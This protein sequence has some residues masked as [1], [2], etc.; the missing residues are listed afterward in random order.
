LVYGSLS[1]NDSWSAT[2]G[3]V[4]GGL[5]PGIG[6]A[7]DIRDFGAAVA[8]VAN[9]DEGAWVELGASI[10]GFVPG[11]DIAKGTTKGA[12]K[13]AAEAAQEVAN[14]ARASTAKV[15]DVLPNG[16][17]PTRARS[18]SPTARLSFAHRRGAPSRTRLHGDTTA[19]HTHSFATSSSRRNVQA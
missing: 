10:I 15:A 7:A 4:I 12:T 11:G 19:R 17:Q 9:G 16:E 8:H 13:I 14:L 3:S 2:A 6:L 18:Q 5:I 1:D